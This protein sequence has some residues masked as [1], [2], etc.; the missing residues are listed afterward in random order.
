MDAFLGGS[1]LL[2]GVQ[3]LVASPKTALLFYG[4]RS[5]RVPH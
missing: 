3:F 2:L 5:V 4:L 1:G